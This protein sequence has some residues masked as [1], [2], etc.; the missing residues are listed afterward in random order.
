MLPGQAPVISVDFPTVSYAVAMTHPVYANATVVMYLEHPVTLLQTRAVDGAAPVLRSA[1]PIEL[2]SVLSVLPS[3]KGRASPDDTTGANSWSS[4]IQ[5]AMN[6]SSLASNALLAS[7]IMPLLQSGGSPGR[8]ALCYVM[9][10]YALP[11]LQRRSR[12]F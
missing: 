2:V 12:C 7:A 9:L 3:R 4:A 5:K 1:A 6:E 11:C 8:A 10:C